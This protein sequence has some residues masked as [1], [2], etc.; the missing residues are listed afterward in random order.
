MSTAAE[1]YSP[2]DSC[3][4]Y[5]PSRLAAAMIKAVGKRAGQSWLE[6]SVGQGVFLQELHKLG[7]PASLITGIDLEPL[8]APAD[9]LGVVNRGVD[10]LN[11]CTTTRSRFHRVVANPPY[12]SL[13]D[14]PH[15]ARTTARQLELESSPGPLPARS[16]LWAAFLIGALKLLKKGGALSIVLP[17]AWDYADY[18]EKLRAEVPK[19]FRDWICLRCEEP[20]FPGVLEGSIVLVGRGFRG[21]H[22]HSSRISCLRLDDLIQQLVALGTQKKSVASKRKRVTAAKSARTLADIVDL[23]LGGVTGDADYF[24]LTE[25]R[26]EELGLPTNAV[27]PVLS[28]ASHLIAANM[29]AAAWAR[30]REKDARVWLFRP[31]KATLTHPNVQSYLRK[32]ATA[33]GCNRAG[34]KVRNRQVWHQ[35]VLPRGIDGFISG[36]SKN[37]PWLALNGMKSLTATNTLYTVHF[38]RRATA[39]EKAAFGLAL[40]S[41]KVR[42]QLPALQRC[43]AAGLGKF[44]PGD[45]QSLKFP[46]YHVPA[47]ATADYQKAVKALLEGSVSAATAIA[48]RSLGL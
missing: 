23:R 42:K 18:G 6:P 11:W 13:L 15:H 43:Y 31:S 24:L 33:G 48:N 44:E 2:P 36:M 26:R 30:L 21:K 9:K 41:T 29:T 17:A 34:E 16:N 14:L 28:K 46:D 7:V 39:D 22:V 47:K 27:K 25:K 10:F 3:K 12:V 19:L 20:L 5:T 35:V 37:G 32:H 1:K 8:P 4:V 38:K 40:L 45:L